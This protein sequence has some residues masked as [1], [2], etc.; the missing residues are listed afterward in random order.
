MLDFDFEKVCSI[1]L[2]NLNT[3]ACLCC[4][5]YL[6]G[7]GKGTHAYM[8]SLEEGHHVFISL[9]NDCRIWCLPDNYEVQDASLNDIKYNLLPL[10]S[11]DMVKRLD[12][13]PLY[14]RSLD[15]TEYYPGCL[16]L[17]NIKQTDYVNVVIQALCRVKP[18]RDF[19]LFYPISEYNIS[20]LK[21]LLVM[22][23]AELVKKVWNPKNF[24]GHVSPH[25]LL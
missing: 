8:H 15:G 11:P 2:N 7:K 9:S 12:T 18:L 3:Y 5:K 16:G 19:C 25:E 4:G 1:S 24:K 10:Y 6:Q 13:E 20:N 23:F 21:H 22:R 14:S 17:N